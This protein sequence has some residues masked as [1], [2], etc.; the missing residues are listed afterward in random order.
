MQQNL[1]C[2]IEKRTQ[3]T[4]GFGYFFNVNQTVEVSFRVNFKSP[5]R[6]VAKPSCETHRHNA[7]TIPY[8]FSEVQ[9]LWSG[10]SQTRKIGIIANFAYSSYFFVPYNVSKCKIRNQYTWGL[11]FKVAVFIG[12]VRF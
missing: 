11:H 10:F 4:D 8:L 7:Q 5:L 12:L 1:I 2:H 6:N 9:A 3:G